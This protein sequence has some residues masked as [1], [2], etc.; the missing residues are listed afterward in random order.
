MLLNKSRVHSPI[1]TVQ[2]IYEIEHTKLYQAAKIKS[3]VGVLI[4]RR[5]KELLRTPSTKSAN[6]YLHRASMQN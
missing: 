6:S 1:S 5:V 3:F 4:R 2:E